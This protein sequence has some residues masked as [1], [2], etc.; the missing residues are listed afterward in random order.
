MTCSAPFFVIFWHLT[1]ADIAFSPE[2]YDKAIAKIN[3]MERD[4]AS[5]RTTA[6]TDQ[7]AERARLKARAEQLTKEKEVH[8]SSV[9]LTRRRLL[10]E[11]KHWFGNCE[12]QSLTRVPRRLRDLS[13]S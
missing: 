12:L 6:V 8:G 9:T 5:W 3:S 1:M 10:R 7:K 4:V 13:H 2:S 11:S